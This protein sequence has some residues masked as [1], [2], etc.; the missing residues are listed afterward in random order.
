MSVPFGVGRKALLT[1]LGV[2]GGCGAAGLLMALDQSVRADLTLHPP[3]LPWSHNGTLDAF[4]HQSIRRGYQVYKQVTE[5]IE[6]E[7]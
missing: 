6:Q 5:E 2:G 7:W 1:A 3:K 4:D